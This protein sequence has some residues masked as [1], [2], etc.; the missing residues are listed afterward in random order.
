MT[1]T[2]VTFEGW[3]VLELMGH[4]QRGGYVK[5]VEMFGGKLLRIDIPVDENTT[6]TEFYGC[7]SIYAMRPC[8]EEIVREH[9]K[10]SMDLRPVR[11]VAYRESDPARLGHDEDRDDDEG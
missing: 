5:D 11:P 1:E 2:S 8:T 4:R 10:R 6:V 7:S 3:A 9:V